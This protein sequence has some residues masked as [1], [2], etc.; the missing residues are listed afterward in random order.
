MVLFNIYTIPF[1]TRI[2]IIASLLEMKKKK[3]KKKYPKLLIEGSIM[4]VKKIPLEVLG[5]PKTPKV[6]KLFL[7][8]IHTFFQ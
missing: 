7:S 2:R 8:L 1:L 6:R 4:K 5:Q 3:K